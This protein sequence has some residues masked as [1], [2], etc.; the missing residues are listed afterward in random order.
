MDEEKKD[1]IIGCVWLGIMAGGLVGATY[2]SYKV[3][4]TIAA[5][6]VVKELIKRGAVL[7]VAAL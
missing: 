2:L 4:G 1:L 7:T 5:K 3:V 6:Q